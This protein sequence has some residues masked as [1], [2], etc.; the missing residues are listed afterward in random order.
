[1]SLLGGVGDLCQLGC[2]I[3]IGPSRKRFIGQVLDRPIED[4]LGGTLGTVGYL[5]SA[6]VQMVRVHDVKQTF[7]VVRIIQAIRQ[8][9]SDPAG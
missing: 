5:A 7:D 4:R 8:S 3:L 9:R 1:M 2:P 6:G